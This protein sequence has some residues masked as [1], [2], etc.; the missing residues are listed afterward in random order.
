MN[1]FCVQ[2]DKPFFVNATAGTTVL[3]AFDPINAVADI[4]EKYDLWMHVD[5]RADSK[6]FILLLRLLVDQYVVYA[7]QIRPCCGGGRGGGK[8]G[9]GRGAGSGVRFVCRAGCIS[10][11]EGLHYK[12]TLTFTPL[13]VR[14]VYPHVSFWS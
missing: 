8:G 12:K 7:E 1:G 4:C 3:G 14:Y 13:R 11:A 9:G 2:G 10:T 5:V 6:K